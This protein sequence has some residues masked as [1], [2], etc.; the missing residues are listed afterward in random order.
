KLNVINST[1]ATLRGGGMVLALWFIAPTIHMF[2]VWHCVMSIVSVFWLRHS[3]WRLTG[4][5]PKSRRFD[6]KAL[7]EV[8]NYTAGVGGINLLGYL[9]TQIDKII[10]SK[11][12]PLH[13]FGYYTLSWN[14]GTFGYRLI[15]PI[16]YAYYPRIAQLVTQTDPDNLT[17][18]EP[19]T[20][21]VELYLR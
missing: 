11:V 6:I 5:C 8:G 20:E 19:T 15:G 17:N 12:L 2:F 18:P 21:L 3:V 13:T 14:L 10:I 1:S 16:F 7:R 9:L 4:Q